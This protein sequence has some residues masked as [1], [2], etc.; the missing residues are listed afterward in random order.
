MESVYSPLK[1][2]PVAVGDLGPA[3]PGPT[4]SVGLSQSDALE[5]LVVEVSESLVAEQCEFAVAG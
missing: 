2:V 1:P 3:P 4:I 5:I